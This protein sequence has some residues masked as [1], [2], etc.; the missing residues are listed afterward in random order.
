[1]AVTSA[2]QR[3]NAAQRSAKLHTGLNCPSHI[4][5]YNSK[6]LK[7]PTCLMFCIHVASMTYTFYK[8]ELHK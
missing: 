2:A 5:T 4:N 6:T 7:D 8:L 1:M 3:R